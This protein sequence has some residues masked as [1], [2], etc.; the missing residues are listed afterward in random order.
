MLKGR[1]PRTA[2]TLESLVHRTPRLIAALLPIALFAAACGGGSETG[3]A[4]TPAAN[5][6]VIQGDDVLD[7]AQLPPEETGPDEEQSGGASESEGPADPPEF[8]VTEDTLPVGEEEDADSVFFEAVGEFTQCLTVEGYDFI[9]I[10]N[11]DLPATDPVNDPGYL[12][13]LGQCAASSQIISKMAAAEDTS[14]LTAEEIETQNREFNV[15]VDCLTGRGWTIPTPTPDENGVL[16]P[17][18][19]ELAQTWVPPDGTGLLD[20]GEFNTDDFGEC[21]FNSNQLN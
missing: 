1:F 15:F 14:S 7:D 6:F 11:E 12:D 4:N 19:V 16:Q 9:G 5:D 3:T 17:P 2:P 8:D 10:P 20:G 13:S 21:G 18:Y